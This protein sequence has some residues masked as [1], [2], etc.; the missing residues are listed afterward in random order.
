PIFI[1]SLKGEE[2]GEFPARWD[3][4]SSGVVEIMEME[5]APVIGFVEGAT[6]APLMRENAY[7]PEDFTLEFDAYFHNK[8]NEAYYLQFDNRKMGVRFSLAGINHGGNLNRTA[9]PRAE[10]WKHLSLSFNKRALKAFLN[11]ERLV[12]VPNITTLP[13]RVAIK[14]LS[15][16]G[17]SGRYA[18]IRN[19]RLMEGGMPLYERLITDGQFVTNKIQFASGSAKILEDAQP[20]IQEV[21]SVLKAHEELKLRIEGHTD[22]DGSPTANKV[23]G[24]KRAEAVKNALVKGGV[25]AARLTTI[26]FGEEKPIADDTTEE[27]KFQNRRVVFVVA[28]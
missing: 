18:V 6:I 14:A 21:L 22:G 20:T 7:L 3:L 12:N 25:A 24:E 26:S 15:H 19:I 27:G 11:G 23:L 2:P 4:T 9:T 1:D 28:Q 8:G 5:G 10:G 16:G 13:T 17:S